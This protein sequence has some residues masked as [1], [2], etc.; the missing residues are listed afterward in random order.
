MTPYIAPGLKRKL[1]SNLFKKSLTSRTCDNIERLVCTYFGVS[2]AQYHSRSRLRPVVNARHLSMYFMRE[3]TGLSLKDIGA[4]SGR[5][6]TSVIH[7][8]TA[9]RGWIA[10]D[11]EYRQQ[12]AELQVILDRKEDALKALE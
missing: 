8:I 6:H 3:H 10:T 7:A 9:V 2:I 5:D 12:V 1:R 4:R 11:E